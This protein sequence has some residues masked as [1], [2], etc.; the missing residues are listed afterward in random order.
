MVDKV[1]LFNQNVGIDVRTVAL[2]CFFDPSINI[3]HLKRQCYT[4]YS[5]SRLHLSARRIINSV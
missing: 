4:S 1:D 3:V 2:D 5:R